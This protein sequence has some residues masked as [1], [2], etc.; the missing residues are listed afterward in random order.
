M[1]V[2]ELLKGTYWTSRPEEGGI[3][4]LRQNQESEAPRF[5]GD[6]AVTGQTFTPDPTGR[7]FSAETSDWPASRFH[8]VCCHVRPC[9]S[10]LLDSHINSYT[11]F[12]TRILPHETSCLYSCT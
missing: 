9:L 8:D 10:A 7:G 5:S 3:Y 12:F 2:L 11:H 4:S 6:V 1:T